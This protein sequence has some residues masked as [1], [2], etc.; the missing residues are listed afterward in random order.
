ME[1]AP[2][3]KFSLAEVGQNIWKQLNDQGTRVSAKDRAFFLE[4]LS[5]LIKSGM[6][7]TA[8]LE[9]IQK[10]A[11]S[12]KMKAVVA[13]I[14]VEID[15][16]AS[17]T[18]ALGKYNF[19]P[20]YSMSLIKAGEKSARFAE[21]LQVIVEQQTKD[22][23]FAS[24]LKGAMMYPVIVLVVGVVIGVG[25]SYFVFPKLITVFEGMGV[26]LPFAT[27]MLIA[28]GKFISKNGAVVIPLFLLGFLSMMYFLF[29][30]PKTKFIGQRIIMRLPGFHQIVFE[31]EMA[32][33][34]Y[35]LGTLFG[36][37]LPILASLEALKESSTYQDYRNLYAHLEHG[38]EEGYTFEEGFATFKNSEILIPPSV[39]QIITTGEKSGNL[40]KALQN[41]GT[42]YETK[43]EITSKNLSTLLEP[44]M[45]VVIFGGVM[46]LALSVL[47]PV[48]GLLSGL[49][50]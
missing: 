38:I 11:R 34:G 18:D 27:R 4:N 48:Y 47:Q 12:P 13:K 2:K 35:L 19:L 7:M 1:E 8:T 20:A 25:L 24:K 21:N 15:S 33:F 31:S 32:R 23:I 42:V 49:D 22:A 30:Y 28:I 50:R 36:A 26:E 16:G 17:F 44:I 9:A 5:T 45:L 3:A 41:I 10:E 39:Q 6:P 46:V 29:L 14:Q 43:I 40:S 37:G